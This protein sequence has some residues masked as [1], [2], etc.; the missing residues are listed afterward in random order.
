M[1]N[2]TGI[3]TDI[4][5]TFALC[6]NESKIHHLKFQ[7]QTLEITEKSIHVTAS[8]H[9]MHRYVLIIW[10]SLYDRSGID[11]SLWKRPCVNCDANVG[12]TSLVYKR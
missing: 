8:D 5:R 6:R 12:Q 11:F 1:K 9:I 4:S 7:L 3:V 2:K 10:G